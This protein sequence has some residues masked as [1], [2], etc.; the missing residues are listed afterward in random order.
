MY[1]AVSPS[2][3]YNLSNE[4]LLKETVK[5]IEAHLTEAVSP[6]SNGDSK[7]KLITTDKIFWNRAF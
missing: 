1:Q 3:A 5:F 4:W 6:S 2:V 7:E